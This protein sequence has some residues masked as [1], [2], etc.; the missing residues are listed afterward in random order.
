MAV[1]RYHGARATRSATPYRDPQ[2]RCATLARMRDLLVAHP[3]LA[4]ALIIGLGV[5]A[6]WLAWR[7]RVPAI[8]PLLAVG[9]LVGPLLG[10]L[11]PSVVFPPDLF[12]P[13]VSMAVGLILFEGGLTLRFAEL[14]DTRRVVI[15]LVTWGA[16]V[17]WL[18]GAAAAYL[19]A[20]L[21]IQLAL[22]FGSLVIVTGPTVIAPLL[23]IVR[24]NAN[25]SSV[26]K[27]ES[28]VIDAVGALVAVLVLEAIV[29]HSR[30]EPIASIALLLGRFII[31]GSATG[32]AGGLA[33]SWLLR[34][35]AIPDY[36]VNVTALAFLFATFSLAN[37][38][39]SEAGLLAA[40][41]MGILVA[42]TGVPNLDALLSFKEDLTVLLVSMLFIALAANV[43]LSSFLAALSWPTVIMVALIVFIIR[44]LDVFLSSIGSR[45]SGRER[46][47]IAWVGPRGIVAA[48][49]TSLFAVR[50][51]AI[52]L[53]GA[54]E[55]VPLVF[56][57]IVATVL[58]ASLTAKP[59]GV[60]LGVADP[61]PQGVLLLGAHPVGRQ[62]GLA[63]DKLGVSVLL[64]DTNWSN[65]SEARADGLQTYFGSL[66][67]D[68]SDD[69]LRLAGIGRL[70]ALTSNDE[71]NALTAV[72]YAREF[73][74]SNVFQ[75]APR[76]QD[77]HGKRLGGEHRGRWL[78][79][80]D[81]SFEN[82]EN[83][84]RAGATVETAELSEQFTLADYQSGGRTAV[85]LFVVNGKGVRVVSEDTE[86]ERE[87]SGMVVSLVAPA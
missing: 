65:V 15:N 80:T 73:G 52:G 61:D 21:N 71:A 18:L 78:S 56:M 35:R 30:D 8:L 63:L 75:L 2:R 46:L 70:V 69:R 16:L 41:V 25:V 17:T 33:L 42:N 60:R 29:L 3:D 84:H 82:I 12:F 36:L 39:S 31:V 68:T 51:Q 83:L 58:L 59:L 28:I 64:A 44:P 76:A 48:S 54:D 86:P 32:A 43:E 85:P 13:L 22:L 37:A 11:Q 66:L 67:A 74:K 14:R 49:V 24:P 79:S 4:I 81:L 38:F 40:V 6:Q 9:F 53:E 34:R 87:T 55:L 47:F 19:V 72:K 50:L 62:I 27:W 77:D 23:R 5:G 10:W 20:G 1:E 57:V 45:L 26:L 7:A